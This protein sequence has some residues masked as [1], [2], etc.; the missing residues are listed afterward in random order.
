MQVMREVV[1]SAADLT[2]GGA[3]TRRDTGRRCWLTEPVTTTLSDPQRVVA[4][5]QKKPWCPPLFVP[6]VAVCGG[7][8]GLG[9]KLIDGGE[10]TLGAGGSVWAGLS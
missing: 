2:D 4:Q 10:L 5:P 6:G 3:S 1:E 9:A 8:T 7:V